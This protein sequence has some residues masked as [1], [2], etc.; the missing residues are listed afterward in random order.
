MLGK[1]VAI[2][3]KGYTRINLT[4]EET[5]KAMQELLQFNI[6]ELK[7]TIMATKDSTVVTLNQTDA[8]KLLFDKQGIASY[9]WLQI[10]L[11]EKIE[12]AKAVNA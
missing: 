2:Q 6:N 5:E 12:N 11:D 1:S 4:K 10:K 7:K 8:V 9:T 3:G